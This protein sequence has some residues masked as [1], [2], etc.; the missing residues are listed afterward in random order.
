MTLHKSDH[1]WRYGEVQWLKGS[2]SSLVMYRYHDERNWY[3]GELDGDEAENGTFTMY[4]L[5]PFAEVDA[6]EVALRL[7]ST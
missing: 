7:L 4:K 5:G 6:A 3:V 2:W 1:I